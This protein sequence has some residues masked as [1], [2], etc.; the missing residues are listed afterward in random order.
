MLAD[1]IRDLYRAWWGQP[2]R[3]A[4]FEVDGFAIDVLKWDA[5]TNPQ[6][7][8]LYASVGA[9]DRPLPGRDSG[10][11][12]EFFVG[13]L[14]AQDGIASPLAAL[15]LYSVREG[16]ALDHGQ[17]VPAGG[18]LWV[19]SPM[20]TFLVVRPQDEFLPALELPNALHVEFLQA[21][22]LLDRELEF[23]RKHGAE[24]MLRRWEETGVRFWDSQRALRPRLVPASCRVPGRR[25]PPAPRAG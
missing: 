16:V 20:R 5:D 3:R 24:S 13:L 8:T 6:G 23:K 15:G 18:P 12:V 1:D 22:P 9:S 21:I 4:H 19:G 11:R 14:P 7:V 10:H 2:A 25:G 17:S